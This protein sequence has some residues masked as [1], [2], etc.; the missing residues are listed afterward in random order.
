[1]YLIKSKVDDLI[2]VKISQVKLASGVLARA[3]QNDP[4]WAYFFPDASKRPEK[5]F[6]VLRMLV[7][8]AISY[9]EVQATS[10]DL[11]GTAVWLPSDKADI[12][13]L[14][15]MRSGGLPVMLRMGWEAMVRS[16]RYTEYASTIPKRHE[17]Q[18][19]WYL[20]FIGVDPIFQG[21]GYASELL[22]PMI[23]RMDAEKAFCFLETQNRENV[24]IYQHYG[25]RVIEEGVIPGTDIGHWAMIRGES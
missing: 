15:M 4:L 8:Y 19:H 20:Q 1:M 6:S 14:Q 22:R 3:F 23:A 5:I 16:M 2:Q 9:G 21:K 10:T 17:Y 18:T 13:P 7:Q 24:P 25:F 12:S 11:E